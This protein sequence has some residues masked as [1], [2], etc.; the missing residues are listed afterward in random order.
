MLCPPPAQTMT[1]ACTNASCSIV[2]CNAGYYNLDGN[3]ANGCECL[4]SI[5]EQICVAAI[6]LGTLSPGQTTIATA[7]LPTANAVAWYSV[8][9]I[10]VDTRQAI[11]ISGN[12]NNQFVMD[13]QGDC[14][15]ATS[16]VG[17]GVATGVKSYQFNTTAGASPTCTGTAKLNTI[18]FKVYR[19]TGLP[20]NCNTFTITVGA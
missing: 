12:P 9:F 19:T 18:Y 6:N 3:Y 2:N 10:A 7:N 11:A 17:G 5:N 4:G 8:S 1:T 13:V 20:V 14:A 15:T 16:C